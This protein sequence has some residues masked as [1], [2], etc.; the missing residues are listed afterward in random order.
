[1][2]IT[3]KVINKI[4]SA[5]PKLALSIGLNTTEQACIWWFHQPKIP[6]KLECLKKN[7]K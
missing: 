4:G 1:M 7:S 2:K 3:E 6:A 5:I